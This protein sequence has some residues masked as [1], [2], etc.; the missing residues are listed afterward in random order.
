MK[1]GCNFLQEVYFLFCL[2]DGENV[3][4]HQI[5]EVTSSFDWLRRKSNLSLED[6]DFWRHKEVRIIEKDHKETECKVQFIDSDNEVHETWL[7]TKVLISLEV[8]WGIG[9]DPQVRIVAENYY[10]I[11]NDEDLFQ[12][13]WTECGLQTPPVPNSEFLGQRVRVED[14]DLDDNT[15][16]ILLGGYKE[17]CIPLAVLSDNSGHGE[18]GAAQGEG[19]YPAVF[20]DDDIQADYPIAGEDHIVF[21]T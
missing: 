1:N 13:C 5:A 20:E 18:G 3:A 11:T 4:L 8:D 12:R 7:P 16:D 15:A 21:V 9:L 19:G 14:I 2:R 6:C 17:V 10:F